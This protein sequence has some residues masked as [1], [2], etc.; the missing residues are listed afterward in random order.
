MDEL[1]QGPLPGGST[2]KS[3]R[4]SGELVV[5]GPEQSTSGSAIESDWG[6]GGV[7]EQVADTVL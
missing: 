3:Q 7:S 1:Q 5:T 4:T 2:P 6:P